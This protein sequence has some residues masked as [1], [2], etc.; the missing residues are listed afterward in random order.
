MNK[1]MLRIVAVAFVLCPPAAFA[2][3]PKAATYITAEEIKKVNAE[4]GIDH[5]LR[6]VDIGNEHLAVGVIH[7]GPSAAG[8][9][10]TAAGSA[11]GAVP[12]GEPCGDQTAA[13][14]GSQPT[15]MASG[16]TH[17]SQTEGYVIISGGGTLITGGH[18]VNGRKSPPESDVTKVLNGPSCSGIIAGADVVKRPVKTGDVVII[19]AGVAHGWIDI[20]D[21]VD[22]LSIRPSDHVLEAGYVHPS[23]RK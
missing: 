11:R 18:I 5:T 3:A 23:M 21:H 14:A 10:S 15:T 1:K 9:G 12:A 17:D 20:T 2:Q 8:T 22:Y 7:R 19:P 6:V 16:I 13:P 4:P